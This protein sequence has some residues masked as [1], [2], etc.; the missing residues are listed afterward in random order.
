MAAAPDQAT[1]ADDNVIALDGQECV[2]ASH[3]MS[4]HE[5]VEA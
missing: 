3:F 5:P 4:A 2:L 1:P